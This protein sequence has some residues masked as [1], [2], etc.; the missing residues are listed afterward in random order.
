MARGGREG[1]ALEDEEGGAGFPTERHRRASCDELRYL[2]AYFK[3]APRS[4]CYMWGKHTTDTPTM[5]VLASPL[6]FNL[7]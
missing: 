1:T 5:C 6:G 7:C 3:F 2:D 4:A